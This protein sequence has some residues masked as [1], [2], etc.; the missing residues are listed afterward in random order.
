MAFVDQADLASTAPGKGA[1]MVGFQQLGT[2][3]SARTVSDKLREAVSI[4]DFGAVGDGVTN[5]TPALLAALAVSNSIYFP[6]GEY[7]LGASN[8]SGARITSGTG[9]YF[10]GEGERS[11][12]R[13]A[14]YNPDSCCLMF[15]SGS[16]T[17][18]IEGITFKDLKFLGDVATLHHE[19]IFGH[20][21]VLHGVKRVR[22]DSCYFEGPR[23]DAVLIGSGPGGGTE[24]HNFDVTVTN[25]VFDGVVH[26]TDGGRNAISFIDI[27][28]ASITGCTFRRWSKNNMP[29]SL[30]FEPDESFGI[31]RNVTISDNHF[32]ECSGNRGHIALSVDNIPNDNWGNIVISSNVISDNNAVCIYS[33]PTLGGTGNGL[34]VANNMM[35]GCEYG[36]LKPSGSLAGLIFSDNIIVSMASGT[37]RILLGNGSATTWT[38]RDVQI[39]GN[40]INCN[41]AAPLVIT[42]NGE[43]VVVKGN[44]V[45]GSTQAHMILGIAGTATTNY[46]IRDNILLGTPSN[47]LC[48]HDAGTHNAVSNMWLD[49]WSPPGLSH[50]FRAVKTDFAG[51]VY[52]HVG[53]DEATA[54]GS[55]PSGNSSVRLK[56]RTINGANQTGILYSHRLSTEAITSVWQEFVPDYA[57]GHVFDRIVRKA[58]SASTWGAWG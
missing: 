17:A 38:V 37:G 20:L 30:C 56:N 47:G 39:S 13:R 58:V 42:D 34:V 43:N 21:L 51:N 2:G 55:L 23:S 7:A 36:L 1:D 53:A 15:D 40:Q 46:I 35:R 16:A 28:G 49:N 44:I 4:R 54:P 10:Y 31:I 45:R 19:E 18:W 5:D 12:I 22:L 26:G 8:S 3:A 25:C 41:V 48:Q 33:N 52:N 29:G 50:G 57:A 11:V 32:T 27:D 9:Y 6:E 24:R 14:G